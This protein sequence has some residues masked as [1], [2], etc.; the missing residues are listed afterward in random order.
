MPSAVNHDIIVGSEFNY[1]IDTTHGLSSDGYIA[2]G[3]ES[4]VYKGI[5][6]SKDGKI[7]LPFSSRSAS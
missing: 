5:K 6:T 3:T 2:T 7:R 1:I 4:I